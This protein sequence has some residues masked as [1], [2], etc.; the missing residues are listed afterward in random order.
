MPQAVTGGPTAIPRYHLSSPASSGRPRPSAPRRLCTADNVARL[1]YHGIDRV[2][3]GTSRLLPP[4]TFPEGGRI[5]LTLRR[6]S[7]P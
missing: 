7:R 3:G 6:V 4:E 1:A 5:N 2:L